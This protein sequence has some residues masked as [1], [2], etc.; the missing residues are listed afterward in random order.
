[1]AAKRGA[2]LPAEVKGVRKR[3]EHRRRT[4]RKRS[5]MPEELWNAAASL[6]RDRAVHLFLPRTHITWVLRECAARNRL[7][8]CRRPVTRVTSAGPCTPADEFPDGSYRT[9]ELRY[10]SLVAIPA[11]LVRSLSRH[12]Y[13][14]PILDPWL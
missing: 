9:R 8:N 6:A 12:Q 10:C 14:R 11:P 7:C 3:I 1:M 5:A 2:A 4:R 13:N